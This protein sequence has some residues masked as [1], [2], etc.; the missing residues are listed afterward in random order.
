MKFSEFFLRA[1]FV[2]F[3]ILFVNFVNFLLFFGVSDTVTLKANIFQVMRR[4]I[5]IMKEY[6]KSFF[7]RMSRRK[8]PN[9][10]TRRKLEREQN[11]DQNQLPRGMFFYQTFIPSSIKIQTM[12]QI[13]TK[14]QLHYI[15]QDLLLEATTESNG[16]HTIITMSF[17]KFLFAMNRQDQP[18]TTN[19]LRILKVRVTRTRTR[20]RTMT[21][22]KQSGTKRLQH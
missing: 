14:L 21:L 6:K 22:T 17:M 13:Y 12:K 5:T 7:L 10:L 19:L 4:I 18:R 1:S 8:P 2:N 20:T 11:L 16:T 15:L 3:G 9:I